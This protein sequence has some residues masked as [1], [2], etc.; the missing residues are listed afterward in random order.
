M[1]LSTSTE[2]TMNREIKFRA[3]D[4]KK[5][6]M[7]L[8]SGAFGNQQHWSIESGNTQHWGMFQVGKKHGRICG[9]ADN[10][11]IL[12]QYTG[13]KDKNGVE[14]YEGDIVKLDDVFDAVAKIVFLQGSFMCEWL[15]DDCY[16]EEMSRVIW[17]R[18]PYTG[19][20]DTFE[21]IGNIYENPELLESTP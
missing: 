1:N 10:S 16:S 15:N 11:G 13:L 2:G 6:R 12:M 8:P 4:K 3:W 21:V 20:A 9:S 19:E 17:T 14:I 7:I 18:R 5:K